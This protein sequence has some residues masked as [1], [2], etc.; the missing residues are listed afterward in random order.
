VYLR[1]GQAKQAIS[2]VESALEVQQPIFPEERLGILVTRLVLAKAYSEE[3]GVPEAIKLLE[4]VKMKSKVPSEDNLR[5]LLSQIILAEWREIRRTPALL[6]RTA[7]QFAVMS[8]AEP[9][10]V[11]VHSAR[12]PGDAYYGYDKGYSCKMALEGEPN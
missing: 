3:E 12:K 4:H 2:L 6:V 10:P 1:N 5:R 9:T 11:P 7:A 8:G